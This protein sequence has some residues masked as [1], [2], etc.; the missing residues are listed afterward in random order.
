VDIKKIPRIINIDSNQ[1]PEIEHLYTFKDFPVFMGT[2][3]KSIDDDLRAD[4][5]IYI[6]KIDGMLQ[7]NPVLP[8]DIVYQHEHNSGTTGKVWKDHHSELALFLS[9]QKPQAI[10]EIGGAHGILSKEYTYDKIPWTIL[11]PNPSPTENCTATFIKGYFDRDFKFN[12]YFDTVVHSHVFE[13]M[14]NPDEFI[15]LLST[16][17]DDGKKLVFSIPNM[18]GML[19]RKYLNF[20]NFEH[21]FYLGDEHAEF[22]LA[23][24]KFRIVDKTYYTED[25][26]IF[27]SVIK[28]TTVTPIQM[29]V[30]I[31]ETNKI[32][33]S[34]YIDH[35]TALVDK[36]NQ[37][38]SISNSPVYQFGAHVFSQYLINF[39]LDIT[40]IVSLLDNDVSKQG[41]RLY[42]TTLYA[43][44][45]KVLRGIKN[46]IVLLQAGPF[47]NE[48]K[49]D[50][51]ENINSTTIFL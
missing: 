36:L 10:F 45:P 6:N 43:E 16:L 37:Q 9:K 17:I 46:P 35:Y 12:K 5:N 7:V 28:D 40:K 30:G 38:I 8:L 29:P 20:M 23:K 2:T 42:G 21:T 14:Y 41:K 32:L 24:Y 47:S 51:L 3:E 50:I 26:S 1:Q 11:E 34:E 18:K 33:F 44:S 19:E 25:H 13:H 27:Y 49:K 39:G 22:L 4:M 15:S 31:Y 48:I